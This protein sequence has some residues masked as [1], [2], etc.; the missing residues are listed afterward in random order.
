[1]TRSSFSR[2]AVV[3]LVVATLAGLYLAG[4][5]LAHRPPEGGRNLLTVESPVSIERFEVADSSGNI[6]W[7]ITS[8]PAR[9]VSSIH[10]GEVPVGF[11]QVLPESGHP[12]PFNPD[13]PLRTFTLTTDWEFSHNGVAI[14]PDKFLGGSYE[15]G[16]RKASSAPTTGV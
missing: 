16:P 4:L 12:R 11:T 1:M 10:Y 2:A 14:G 8:N 3:G 15:N 13:E 7:R 5:Y 9:H 6:L